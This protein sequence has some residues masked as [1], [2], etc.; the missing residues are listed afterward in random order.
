M[1]SGVSVRR[2]LLGPRNDL[3]ENDEAAESL[4]APLLLVVPAPFPA[5]IAQ[6]SDAGCACRVRNCA[7]PVVQ[8]VQTFPGERPADPIVTAMRS[9]SPTRGA[10]PT[11]MLAQPSIDQYHRP[12]SVIGTPAARPG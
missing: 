12:W 7:A 6:I 2:A 3:S 8:R 1:I 11:R 5:T 9:I 4:R 10:S